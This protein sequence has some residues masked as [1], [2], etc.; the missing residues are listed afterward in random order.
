M[1]PWDLMLWFTSDA[2]INHRVDRDELDDQRPRL[3]KIIEDIRNGAIADESYA[4]FTAQRRF[5]TWV[6]GEKSLGED[7][8]VLADKMI[9]L[10][11][12]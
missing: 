5:L 9:S 12:R 7:W 2:D 6:C 4:E 11:E 10:I 3:T 8:K 1:V